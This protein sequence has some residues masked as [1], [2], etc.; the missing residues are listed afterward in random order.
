VDGK[1]TDKATAEQI[2][3]GDIDNVR[4]IKDAI[5]AKVY[6]EKGRNGVIIINTKPGIVKNKWTAETIR[7]I[8]N[9]SDNAFGANPLMIV[10]DI[11]Y[12]GKT[13]D[14]FTE[15]SGVNK[16]NSI[17]LYTGEEAVKIF[18]E[19]AKDGAVIAKTSS[20]SKV[21][22][23]PLSDK[24]IEERILAGKQL[25]ELNIKQNYA[26][27]Q[28]VVLGHK[29]KENQLMLEKQKLDNMND[30]QV[31]LERKLNEL[32][33]VK[34]KEKLLL[35]KSL[36]EKLS[37]D[38]LTEERVVLG[39]KMK[40]NDQELLQMKQN[41]VLEKM[42]AEKQSLKLQE[43]QKAGMEIELR[44][45]KEMQAQVNNKIFTRVEVNP[46]FTG[47]QEAWEK[48]IQE[49]LNSN[50]LVKHGAK[51]G[52]YQVVLLFVVNADGSLSDIK[53]END[54]GFGACDEA[55]RFIKTTP[56]WQPA[57]QNGHKVNAYIK[58]P[59]TFVIT[60]N[61]SKNLWNNFKMENGLSVAYTA[62]FS[63]N[64]L[65]STQIKP[66]VLVDVHPVYNSKVCSNISS[67]K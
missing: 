32:D 17:V 4:I 45:Q 10:D 55:L 19:R 56:K 8:G 54:P 12:L 51:P 52:K 40:L 66:A 41:L 20:P 43:M 14:E 65:L 23:E 35:D 29:L 58:Q 28:K 22:G 33:Q 53:C 7:V 42:A 30:Y 36:P 27:Q 59:V 39:Q 11:E 16:F 57:V 9:N 46:Q 37:L 60:G 61:L 62:T 48:F 67:L 21:A 18:G 25:Q 5:A 47:G 26:Q 49:N 34:E 2:K 3:P 50:V 64:H 13:L 24:L 31:I 1:E 15:L 63:Y 6:G 38:K 44:Q